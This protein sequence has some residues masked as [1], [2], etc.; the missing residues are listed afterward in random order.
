VNGDGAVDFDDL[1][2]VVAAFGPCP[3]PPAPCPEDVD[4]TGEVA[5]DDLLAVLAAWSGEGA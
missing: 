1:L 5:F 3:A 4:G 2:A